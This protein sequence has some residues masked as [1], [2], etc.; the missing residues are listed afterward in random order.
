MY[1]KE[2]ETWFRRACFPIQSIIPGF[3]KGEKR[4]KRRVEGGD[5]GE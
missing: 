2:I 5:L 3:K 1:K 4:L